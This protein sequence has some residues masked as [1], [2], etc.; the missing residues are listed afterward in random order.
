MDIFLRFYCYYNVSSTNS[1]SCKLCVR[2]S[3]EQVPLIYMTEGLSSSV[4][5]SL[6]LQEGPLP[7]VPFFLEKIGSIIIKV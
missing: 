3:E 2:K 4:G 6:R 5:I 1:E 7:L